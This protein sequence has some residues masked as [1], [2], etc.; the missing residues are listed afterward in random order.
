MSILSYYAR[1]IFNG[2]KDFEF[3]KSPLKQTDLN[4]DIFIYSAKDDKSIIGTL[5]VSEILCGNTKE[6][7]QKTGYDKRSDGYEIVSYF[8]KNNQKCFALKIYD[9]KIFN[10]PISLAELRKTNPNVHLPQYYTYINETN[11]IYKL[12]K[13][14]K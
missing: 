11:S 4:K 8:G 9:T 2:T 10:T 12:L 7:L 1:Q 5:K 13:N 6:I 3:R 14:A